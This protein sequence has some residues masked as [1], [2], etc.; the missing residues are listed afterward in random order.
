M[1]AGQPPRVP[2]G[3]AGGNPTYRRGLQAGLA[4]AG[5]EL[6]TLDDP[7][8]WA[9]EEDDRILLVYLDQPEYTEL[10][11]ELSTGLLTTLV[12]LAP[13]PLAEDYVSL[14]R[15]GATAVIDASGDLEVVVAALDM[16]MRGYAALS[17][18]S[19]HRLAAIA[20]SN[21]DRPAVADH[22]VKWLRLLGDGKTTADI[23]DLQH[24][25]VRT[26]QRALRQLYDRLGVD[27]RAQAIAWAGRHGLLDN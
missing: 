24:F 4:E 20:R 6:E 18:V 2:I 19:L 13:E 3:L 21:V 14:I 7:A 26:M 23:A 10:V 12:A 25:S 11:R 22:E 9:G 1:M 5:W 16:L 27:G 15:A 17:L 8:A